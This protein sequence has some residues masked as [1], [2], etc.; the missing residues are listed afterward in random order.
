MHWKEHVIECEQILGKGWDV[1]HHWLDEYAKIYWPM[2]VHRVHRHHLQGIQ[3]V[4]DKWG[5]EA[6]K[7]AEMHIISDEGHIPS[8]YE[9]RMRWGRSPFIEDKGEYPT[10][11][12]KRDKDFDGVA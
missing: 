10:Y 7:A 8:K 2:K 11:P 3:E 1:V 6:A 4:R 5:D 9:A 12:N